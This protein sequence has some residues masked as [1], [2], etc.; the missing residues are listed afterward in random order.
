LSAERR[1]SLIV[2]D[3]RGLHPA[4]LILTWGAVL[5]TVLS[6]QPPLLYAS[7]VV[8]LM[9]GFLFSRHA[10]LLLLRRSRWLLLSIVL[11]FGWMTPGMPVSA[12]PGLTDAGLSQALLHTARLLGSL[13]WVA[14]LLDR[15]AFSQMLSGFHSLLSPLAWCGL[16]VN[17]AVLRLALTMEKLKEEEPWSFDMMTRS[18]RAAYGENCATTIRLE[19]YP[20]KTSDVVVLGVMVLLLAGV[21]LW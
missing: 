7:V 17:R 20:F 12:V 19:M 14:L 6:L 10:V 11:L 9:S 8:M 4:T 1:T 21:V 18:N 13:A 15:M 3:G 2:T 16:N 5:V